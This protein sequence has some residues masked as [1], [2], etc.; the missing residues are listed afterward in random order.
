MSTFNDVTSGADQL[1][2]GSFKEELQA[3]PRMHR[4]VVYMGLVLM[5]CLF[6]ESILILPTILIKWGWGYTVG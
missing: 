1:T 2:Y 5:L 6:L 3:M 4:M